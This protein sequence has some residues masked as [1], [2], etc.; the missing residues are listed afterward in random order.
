LGV[1]P[2]LDAALNLLYFFSMSVSTTKQILGTKAL[3]QTSGPL[4]SMP[5]KG[6][7]L[8]NDSPRNFAKLGEDFLQAAKFTNDGFKNRFEW[9]TYF[10]VY[11]SLEHYLKS[12]LLNRGRTLDYVHKQIGHNLKR[13]LDEAKAVGLVLNAPA[14]FEELVMD[15]GSSYSNKD[16]Q[17][18]SMGSFTVTLP[19]VLIGF[20][21]HVRIA[22]GN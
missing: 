2:S 6:I 7:L 4:P 12:Y 5:V 3:A 11:Q 15:V 17:Y 18:R 20:V 19:D 13:A 1:N 16:F 14:G 21:E 8:G 10:L 9:P 22:S